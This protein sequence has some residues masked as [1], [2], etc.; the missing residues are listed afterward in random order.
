MI[1]L[2]ARVFPVRYAVV[3]VFGGVVPVPGYVVR[4]PLPAGETAVTLMTTDFA[5]VGIPQT[6]AA[7]TMRA[8]PDGS[9]VKFRESYMRQG[10]TRCSPAAVAGASDVVLTVTVAVPLFA[11]PQAFVTRTQYEVVKPG[12]TLTDAPVAPAI[13]FAVFPDV[14][15]YHWYENGAVPAVATVRVVE[16]PGRIDTLAG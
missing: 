4:M 8:V 9:A 13:G 1:V 5:P 12:A 10:V 3:I 14:P 11:L 7:C 6:P 16:A 2:L 15:M